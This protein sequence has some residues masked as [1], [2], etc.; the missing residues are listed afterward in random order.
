MP[1]S[2]EYILSLKLKIC[3]AISAFQA[4]N[5]RS[6]LGNLCSGWTVLSELKLNACEN[7][8]T[9]SHRN[10]SDCH[11]YLM[12]SGRVDL[13]I[14]AQRWDFSQSG[15][16]RRSTNPAASTEPNLR[17]IKI[18]WLQVTRTFV[19]SDN[20]A[21]MKPCRLAFS[22]KHVDFTLFFYFRQSTSVNL[23]QRLQILIFLYQQIC[24]I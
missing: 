16:R 6:K 1:P 10:P 4:W 9:L 23:N 11:W 20:K 14:S 21:G 19:F 24:S 17:P 5:R 18:L 15:R 8:R 22:T 3:E 7:V 12:L 13:S 2:Y